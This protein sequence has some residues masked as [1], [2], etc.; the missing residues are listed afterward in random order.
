MTLHK[1]FAR[2]DDAAERNFAVKSLIIY[3][4]SN[5]LWKVLCPPAVTALM[6]IFRYNDLPLDNVFKTL[7]HN[8]FCDSIQAGWFWRATEKRSRTKG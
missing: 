2:P 4:Q 1:G 7:S 3:D 5:G 6:P 8:A